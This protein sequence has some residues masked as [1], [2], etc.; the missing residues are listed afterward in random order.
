MVIDVRDR[1]RNGFTLVELLLV[2]GLMATIAAIVIP[3]FA[4]QIQGEELPASANQLRSLLTIISANASFDGKRYRIRF[5]TEDETDALG[6]K[7]QPRIEREDDPIHDPEVFDLVTDPWAIG[8]TLIG[9]IRCAEVRLEKPTIESLQDLQSRGRSDVADVLADRE[10]LKD[11]APLF[12]PL[13][14]EPDG[15][16]EWAVFVLTD[17]PP[18]AQYDELEDFKRIEVILEGQ[19]GFCWLQR[20]LYEAELDLFEEKGWPAVLRQDFLNRPE[21]TEN[22]ILELREIQI[23]Q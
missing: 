12:P 17:A 10:E 7:Q 4:R 5:P 8:N 14:I 15:T 6:G 9:D 18:E 3:N 11:F 23:K 1:R 22:D 19:T 20:P 21:L 16:S 2:V 13:Y